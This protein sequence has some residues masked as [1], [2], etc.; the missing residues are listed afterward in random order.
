MKDPKRKPIV[1]SKEAHQ[2]AL[3]LAGWLRKELRLSTVTIGQAAG[4]AISEAH[5]RRQA[6]QQKD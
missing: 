2:Q 3:E 1:V 4:I 6:Y 5:E